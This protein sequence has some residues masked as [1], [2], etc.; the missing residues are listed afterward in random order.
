[1][2]IPGQGLELWETH[3]DDLDIQSIALLFFFFCPLHLLSMMDLIPWETLARN[4]SLFSAL[5]YHH[6][7][8]LWKHYANTETVCTLIHCITNIICN[9]MTVLCTYFL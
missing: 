6:S 4:I 3:Q 1:M 9:N 7:V 5:R 2:N 8:S